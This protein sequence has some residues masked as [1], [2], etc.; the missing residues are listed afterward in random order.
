MKTKLFIPV[1]ILLSTLLSCS[2]DDDTETDGDFEP[3]KSFHLVSGTPSQFI[4]YRQR[5]DGTLNTYDYEEGTVT[6]TVRNGDMMTVV[7]NLGEQ[8][9][10]TVGY[11]LS[12]ANGG[13]E[14]K[15]LYS[16]PNTSEHYG[17]RLMRTEDGADSF[18]ISF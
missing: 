18:T 3:Y 2:G 1:I 8:I 9:L 5:P 13:G 11:R 10:P 12:D 15:T 7:C 14:V 4:V 16:S 17:F 6:F